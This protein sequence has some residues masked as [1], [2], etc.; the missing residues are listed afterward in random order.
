MDKAVQQLCAYLL[1]NELT[2][3]NL[4]FFSDGATNIRT[5]I[6]SYFGEQ[7]TLHLDW[8]HLELHVYQYLSMAI[9]G[10]KDQRDKIRNDI[11]CRLWAGNIDEAIDYIKEL[12]SSLKKNTYR[13]QELIDYLNRKKPYVTCN[14]LRKLAGIRNSS[15][16]AEKANDIVVA[17]REKHQGMSW[18]YLG[19]GPWLPLGRL[20]QMMSFGCMYRQECFHSCTKP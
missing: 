1:A 12:D 17:Q 15:S 18:S 4:I 11:N 16:L 9:K 19:V 7:A 3:R 2:G 13:H 6:A 20:V 8:Y 10:K 14:A 5:T